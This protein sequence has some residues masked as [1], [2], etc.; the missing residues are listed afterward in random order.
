MT[1][2]FLLVCLSSARITDTMW[3]DPPPVAFSF[4][5]LKL[6]WSF[7][8]AFSFTT[9]TFPLG[10]HVNRRDAS[11]PPHCVTTCRNNSLQSHCDYWGCFFFCCFLRTSLF[12]PTCCERVGP[13]FPEALELLGTLIPTI[14]QI[15]CKHYKYEND[16]LRLT[17][18]FLSHSQH[19]HL[20][21]LIVVVPNNEV[22]I[23]RPVL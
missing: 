23:Y 15:L 2:S 11:P 17:A 4:A 21:L 20:K 6:G 16:A 19:E 3:T 13:D 18:A 5:G 10:T 14:L 12:D 1:N 9:P 8:C 22:V 7:T